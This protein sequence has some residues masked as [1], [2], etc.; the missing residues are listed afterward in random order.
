MPIA[1]IWELV[2][3]SR[4]PSDWQIGSSTRPI[5]RLSLPRPLSAHLLLHA[6][7]PPLP[8]LSS[9]SSPFV[10]FLPFP[11]PASAFFTSSLRSFVLHLFALLGSKNHATTTACKNYNFHLA[12]HF[13]ISL[14]VSL[15]TCLNVPLFLT[16]VF[17]PKVSTSPIYPPLTITTQTPHLP[18][19]SPRLFS[20]SSSSTNSHFH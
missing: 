12:S 13:F 14:R 17:G 3:F 19:P 7:F 18:L 16:C 15:Y 2:T 8:P 10:H 11:P 6:L 20:S 5:F 9:T 4:P 1:H